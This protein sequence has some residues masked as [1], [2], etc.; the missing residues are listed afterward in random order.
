MNKTAKDVAQS[1]VLRYA[2]RLR[3]SPSEIH[4]VSIAETVDI[5]TAVLE[6]RGVTIDLLDMSSRAHTGTF[7]ALLAALAVADAL[8]DGQAA[9]VTASSGNTAEA[10]AAYATGH[11]IESFLFVPAVSAYKLDRRW[12]QSA[13]VHL[14]VLDVPEPQL[15]Q[16]AA[17]FSRRTGWPM[18]PTHRHQIDSNKL[19]A[20]Y[21][22]D[23][24]R[25]GAPLHDWTVQAL[26]G[27]YGP[28]GF[29]DGIRELLSEGDWPA[30]QAPK[31]LGVQQQAVCPFVEETPERTGRQPAILEPT[32]YATNPKHADDLRRAV[33][34]FGGHCLAVDNQSYLQREP[35]LVRLL[36]D[37]GLACGRAVYHPEQPVVERSG[38]IALA[39]T[40]DA[41]DQG[42]I[43]SGSRVLV[44]FTGGCCPDLTE[45]ATAEFSLQAGQPVEEFW[46]HAALYQRLADSNNPV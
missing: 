22:A 15:K 18:L 31:L 44:N 37:H 29:Y 43:P 7:K 23:R 2:A 41:I 38:L 9:Y 4:A 13:G 6:R 39:G 19:R 30:D 11:G 36:A 32:L 8:R 17:G 26:S 34:E 12:L 25:G 3:Y 28:I 35:E 27:G 45:P 16:I 20:Y 21:L 10:M 46:A 14:F 5:K 33:R 24:Y 1:V 42:I 40:Q